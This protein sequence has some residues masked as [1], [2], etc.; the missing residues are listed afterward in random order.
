MSTIENLEP[1]AEAIFTKLGTLQEQLRGIPTAQS[2]FS[3]EHEMEYCTDAELSEVF[4]RATKNSPSFRETKPA[5]TLKVSL[6][7]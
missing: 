7:Y 6:M 3:V 2:T 1:S 5:S 4:I